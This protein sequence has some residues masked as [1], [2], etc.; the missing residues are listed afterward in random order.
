MS[1]C[2]CNETPQPECGTCG[3]TR[4]GKVWRVLAG[5]LFSHLLKV[6]RRKTGAS[7]N[8]TGYGV[9]CFFRK[10][11]YDFAV[12]AY[13]TAECEIVDAAKGQVRVKLGAPTTR[14]MVDSGFFDVE[15]YSLDDPDEVYRVLHGGYVVDLE[16]TTV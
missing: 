10:T 2:S 11:K 12:P 6:R 14:L 7:F 9:R 1:D 5:S 16:V 4:R 13:A 15:V 8:L 3:P